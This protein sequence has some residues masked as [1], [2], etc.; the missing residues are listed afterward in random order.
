MSK[1]NK[2]IILGL[3]KAEDEKQVDKW[4][5]YISE[6]YV[7][8]VSPYVGLGFN[9]DD[10]EEGKLK[11]IYLAKCSPAEKALQIGDEIVGMVDELH[12]TQ[13]VEELRK[14]I[15]GGW[16][17]GEI[18]TPIT[19]TVIR[20]GAKMDLELTR[21]KIEGLDIH[22]AKQKDIWQH[23][24]LTAVDNQKSELLHYFEDGD[25]VMFYT[26][27]SGTVN[28]FGRSAIWEEAMVARIKD[29][30]LVEAW[31]VGPGLAYYTQLG[32]KI[33][34]PKA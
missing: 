20:D 30:K 15:M 31:S 5:E 25:M 28:E 19:V 27:I 23:N 33:E 1:S 9:I 10:S 12:S 6:D 16:G 4:V 3:M 32:F 26:R 7:Y 17:Q 2:E 24:L 34:P 22:Y 18:G 11:V 8:H 14:G 21:A 29:G 13:S